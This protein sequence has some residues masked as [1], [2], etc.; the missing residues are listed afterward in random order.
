M[1]EEE[2]LVREGPEL[3][4]FSVDEVAEQLTLM[5]VVRTLAGRGWG[6]CGGGWGEA[7][8]STDFAHSPHPL[9]SSSR[10]CDPAS[11]WAPCGRSETGRGPQAPPLPC[12]PL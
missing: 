9:R 6:G 11:A 2:R 3:L 7:P 10:A 8:L 1:E 4:D 12:A 5:D